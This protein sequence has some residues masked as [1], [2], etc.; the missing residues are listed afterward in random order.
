[1]TS[2]NDEVFFFKKNY[3]EDIMAISEDL[4][5]DLPSLK[6]IFKRKQKV[7][8]NMEENFSESEMIS[9]NEEFHKTCTLYNMLPD[10][11]DD[12]E[13]EEN[14]IHKS[15]YFQIANKE[16]EE[17]RKNY[18]TK[19][20]YFFKF[21]NKNNIHNNLNYNKDVNFYI[22]FCDSYIKTFGDYVLKAEYS[23]YIGLTFT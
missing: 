20:W 23:F 17:E 22:K 4:E 5:N 3:I 6:A 12:E 14:D 13:E 19:L 15:K 21:I 2:E 1:M 9:D 18:I 11:E 10:E 8:E 7:L 16:I